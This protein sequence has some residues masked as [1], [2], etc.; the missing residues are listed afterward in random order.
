M[1]LKAGQA[2]TQGKQLSAAWS[3]V[4]SSEALEELGEQRRGDKEAAF[5]HIYDQIVDEEAFLVADEVIME[6][7]MRARIMLELEEAE[8][9]RVREAAEKERLEREAAARA[10]LEAAAAERLAAAAEADL[11]EADA[12]DADVASEPIALTQ[13]ERHPLCA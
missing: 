8:A 7:D 11:A 12:A 6:E 1:S 10:R 13:C 4:V 5:T 3:G 2:I 9:K